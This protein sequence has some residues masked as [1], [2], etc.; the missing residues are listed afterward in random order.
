MRVDSCKG[1][2]LGR[3]P[4]AFS[5][6]PRIKRSGVTPTRGQTA[7]LQQEEIECVNT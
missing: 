5:D 2:F 7:Y 3:L 6:G 1:P 4:L